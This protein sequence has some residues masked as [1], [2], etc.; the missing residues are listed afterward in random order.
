MTKWL[1]EIDTFRNNWP[2]NCT[3]LFGEIIFGS[4][5]FDSPE[6][7]GWL[8]AYLWCIERAVIF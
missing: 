8:G 3:I 1:F 2:N 6:V 5:N 4:T 7:F